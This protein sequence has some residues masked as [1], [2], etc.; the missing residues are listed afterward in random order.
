MQPDI[1]AVSI[2]IAGRGALAAAAP[3]EDGLP[4]HW[5]QGPADVQPTNRSRTLRRG[6]GQARWRF[7]WYLDRHDGLG[8]REALRLLY[9]VLNHP[10]S[11]ERAG[12]QF[13]RTMDREAAHVWLRIAPAAESACGEGSAGCYSWGYEAKPVVHIGSEYA[14]DAGAFALLVNMEL[15]GHACFRMLDMYSAA[16]QPYPGGVMG[17]W[18]DAARTNYYPSSAEITAAREWLQGRAAHVHWD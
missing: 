14:G 1:P 15:G 9:V 17:T 16:H 13:V 2:R 3:S 10:L 5:E 18:G 4:H 12:V 11:W 7:S 6:S 8:R